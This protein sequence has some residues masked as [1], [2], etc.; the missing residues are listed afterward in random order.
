MLELDYVKVTLL[1]NA[2]RSY[3][4]ICD[5]CAGFQLLRYRS[6]KAIKSSSIDLTIVGKQA[7]DDLQL[8]Q[9]TVSRSQNVNVTSTRC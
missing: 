6:I 1:M 5:K 2:T 9:L 3:S 7:E 4:E 8:K